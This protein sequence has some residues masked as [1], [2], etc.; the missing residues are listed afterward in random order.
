MEIKSTLV[1]N[2]DG[3]VFDVVYRD[4]E[5]LSEIEDRV[6]LG[7]HA[8]CLCDGKLVL[9]YNSRDGGH[10]SVPG[11]GIE[12]G[13]SVEDAVIREIQEETNMKVLSQRLLGFQDIF[14]PDGIRTQTR[15][16]CIVE[17][18]GD[19]VSDPDG[20]ISKI[21]LIDP[22]DYKQYFDWGVVGEHLMTRV[23]EIS[24]K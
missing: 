10:W 24:A 18:Y 4:I 21:M 19:F 1:G 14:T 15:S 20:D 12:E 7:V 16:F 22:A 5:S 17:P 13:E 3:K 2:I 9:V 23:I 6:I 11:G 8:F